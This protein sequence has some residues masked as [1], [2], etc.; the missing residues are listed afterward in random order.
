MRM[1][2]EQALFRYEDPAQVIPCLYHNPRSIIPC[3]SFQI[4]TEQDEPRN[5]QCRKNVTDAPFNVHMSP[6]SGTKQS[7]HEGNSHR[8]SSQDVQASYDMELSQ[9]KKEIG[10]SSYLKDRHPTGH[11]I[12]SFETLLLRY[13]TYAKQLSLNIKEMSL[14]FPNSLEGKALEFFYTHLLME[15]LFDKSIRMM[16]RQF[17]SEHHRQQL[18]SETT[19]LTI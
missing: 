6:R 7:I 4:P 15:T 19:A 5:M 17:N 13:E 3:P 16:T 8:M 9:G 2:S 11:K 14:C 18:S 1:N 10:V 12:E